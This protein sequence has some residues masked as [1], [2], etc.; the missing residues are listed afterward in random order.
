MLANVP[1][2]FAYVAKKDLNGLIRVLDDGGDPNAVEQHN[3]TSLLIQAAYTGQHEM[4]KVLVKRGAWVDHTDKFKQTALHYAVFVGKPR[5]VCTG[6]HSNDEV[7]TSETNCVV[8][9][10]SSFQK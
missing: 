8:S 3:Q 4:V 2:A 9:I 1:E 10:D 6:V 7:A 5:M